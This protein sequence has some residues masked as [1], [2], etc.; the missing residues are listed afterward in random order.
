MTRQLRCLVIEDSQHDQLMI[1]RA[2]ASAGVDAAV[3]VADT[4]DEA[5]HFLTAKRYSIILCDNSLP[6]GNGADF[7]QELADEPKYRNTSIVIV[8][9]WPSPFMWA[10]A[11]AAGLRVIDKNDQPQAKLSQVFKRRS[12]TVGQTHAS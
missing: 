12:R 8:S 11:K 6:D 10:K 2:I 4:L 1:K 3:D 7:A 5:R 9:G